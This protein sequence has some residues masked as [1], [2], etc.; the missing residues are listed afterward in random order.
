MDGS[1]D[2][3][4]EGAPQRGGSML[5]LSSQS[6]EELERMRNAVF[7]RDG[8]LVS[9]FSMLRVVPRRVLMLF[10]M[11]DLLRFVVIH[12]SCLISY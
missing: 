11:N 8:L 4:T 9:L 7:E 6:E 1:W 10:K 2:D 5:E 12:Y 3:S